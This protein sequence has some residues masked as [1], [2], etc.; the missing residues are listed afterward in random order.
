MLLVRLTTQIDEDG[1]QAPATLHI[2][3]ADFQRL[4]SFDSVSEHL[5]A[6]LRTLLVGVRRVCSLGS[7]SSGTFG[8]KWSSILWW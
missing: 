8:E 3:L 5:C 2:H 6:L 1:K 7:V 4:R